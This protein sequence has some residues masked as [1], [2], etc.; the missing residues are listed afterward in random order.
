MTDSRD[1]AQFFDGFATTFDSLYDHKRNS[2]MQWIDRKFRSDMFRRFALSFEALGDL[3]GKTVLD[4][5]CG[6]GPYVVEAL[7]RGAVHVTALDPAPNMLELARK[8]VERAGFTGRCTFLEGAFPG[9]VVGPHDHVIVMGV[10]DYIAYPESFLKA[11][12]PI[13]QR[14]VVLSFSSRHWFRT[15][16]R[17]IRYTIRRCP[18]FFYRHKQIR[19]LSLSAGFDSIRIQKIPGAGMDYH[20]CLRP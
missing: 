11:L 16:I 12:L 15:P 2:A 3:K 8:R 19:S 20:V 14:S 17:K 5:G 7:R 1:A 13:V 18:V 9:A 6:S 10:M 4:I